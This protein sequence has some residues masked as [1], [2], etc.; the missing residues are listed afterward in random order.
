[1]VPDDQATVFRLPILVVGP[2]DVGRLHRELELI[3][4]TVESARLRGDTDVK[5]PKTSHLMDQLIEINKIDPINQNDRARLGKFLT[6]IKTH[7][8]HLHMSFSADPS[9]QFVQKL[10]M[11]LRTEIHP[12]VLLTVGLQPSIGAGCVVRTTNKYFDFSL[13]KDFS[14]QTPLL[15]EKLRSLVV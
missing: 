9:P 1:M 8:P 11:W 15:M 14:K 3:H 10:M 4:N 12:N 6:E 5:L 2:V 13:A 7:A